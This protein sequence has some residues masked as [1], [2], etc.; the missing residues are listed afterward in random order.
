MDPKI[1]QK[2]IL[3][4]DLLRKKETSTHGQVLRLMPP[5]IITKEEIDIA[6][7]IIEASLKEMEKSKQANR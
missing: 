7:T 5:L 3:C 1:T 2:A 4:L 6:V